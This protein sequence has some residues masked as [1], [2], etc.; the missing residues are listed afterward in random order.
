MLTFGGP[1]AAVLALAPAASA[2]P[3]NRNCEGGG[4]VGSEDSSYNYEYFVDQVHVAMNPGEAI[5]L[6]R[7]Q[8][9]QEFG[10][11][12]TPQSVVCLVGDAIALDAGNKWTNWSLNTGWVNVHTTSSGGSSYIGLYRCVG[13]AGDGNNWE[14]ERCTTNFA[15]GKVTGTFRLRANPATLN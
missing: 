10:Y 7:R 3:W 6:A 5:R 4:A 2:T 9:T 1:L 12:I 11:R 8:P 15:G 13:I 14:R